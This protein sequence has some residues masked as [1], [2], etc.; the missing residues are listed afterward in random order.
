VYTTE[1]IR[2]LAALDERHNTLSGP[3]T[4]KLCER[5]HTIFKQTQY[6][7]L[8]SI[9]IAHLYNLRKSQPYL[10]QRYTFEKTRPK[11]ALI[12]IR[13]KPQANG[14]PGFI[15]IDTV[16]QDDQ[17]KQKGVYHI[18]AVDEVTQ[19]EVVCTV[20]KISEQYL[21]P[22]IENLTLALLLESLIEADFPE[23]II[24]HQSLIEPS[25]QIEKVEDNKK[26]V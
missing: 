12:G 23:V 2:L 18:N 7:R 24:L 21:M 20:E 15:R 22:A 9:S 6:Q 5:A 4:K 14:Q 11:V 10:R 13:K 26:T 25:T 16:H 8:A 19:F 3:A 17:D 1:D